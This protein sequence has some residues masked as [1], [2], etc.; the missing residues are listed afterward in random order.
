[1]LDMMMSLTRGKAAFDHVQT[2]PATQLVRM[3][4]RLSLCARY[5]FYNC[6]IHGHMACRFFAHGGGVGN[7]V[8]QPGDSDAK[9]LIVIVGR[10]KGSNSSD[11]LESGIIPWVSEQAFV[12]R[13]ILQCHVV[14]SWSLTMQT[15]SKYAAGPRSDSGCIN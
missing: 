10:Q 4:A 15:L 5:G 12:D 8:E 6:N 14:E 7:I 1:M 3:R 11:N 2:M 9:L 13:C